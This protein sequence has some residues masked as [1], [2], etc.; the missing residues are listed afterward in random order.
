MPKILIV[1]DTPDNIKLMEFCLDDEDDFEL[2]SAGDGEE[3]LRVAKEIHPDTI[4]LDVMMPIM[5]G[6]EVCRQLRADPELSQVPVILVT[7]MADEDDV[8]RGLNAGA[9]DYVTKPFNARVVAART[10]AAVQRYKMVAE[11]RRL[12]IELELAARKDPLTNLLNRRT[13]FE[14]FHHDLMRSARDGADCACVMLDVDHFK[15]INDTHGHLAGDQALILIAEALTETA[16][17]SDAVGRYG[18][19]EF[20]VLLPNTPEDGGMVWAERARLAIE[21][22]DFHWEGKPVSLTASFGVSKVLP[23]ERD[24]QAIINRADMALFDAKTSGRNRVV[25]ADWTDAIVS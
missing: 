24:V 22:I 1:D 25:L 19:E 2:Y 10:R 20:V 14:L 23:Q 17:E 5:D 7:A 12:M 3:G 11:N 13:F 9:D 18:G 21:S 4:L 15:S 8:V 16:R 6:M